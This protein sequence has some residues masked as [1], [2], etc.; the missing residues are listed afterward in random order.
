MLLTGKA[1]NKWPT[2]H[3]K[4][5]WVQ[6]CSGHYSTWPPYFPELN[7]VDFPLWGS[8]ESLKTWWP[9][10]LYSH[11]C[12]RQRVVHVKHAIHCHWKWVCA[13]DE[14]SDYATNRKVPGLSCDDDALWPWGCLGF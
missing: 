3:G 11:S 13:L 9:D 1:G 2:C 14:V 4:K 6:L 8:C 5:T 10:E 7:Q 12:S